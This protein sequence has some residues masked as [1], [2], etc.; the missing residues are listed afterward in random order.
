[1]S[2]LCTQAE[3]FH[4]RRKKTEHNKPKERRPRHPVRNKRGQNGG[5]VDR[6]AAEQ[7]PHSAYHTADQRKP[8][9]AGC[10]VRSGDADALPH[11]KLVGTADQQRADDQQRRINLLQR[12]GTAKKD[13]HQT[14]CP[15][16]NHRRRQH[17]RCYSQVLWQISKAKA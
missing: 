4:R 7:F 13:L 14:R 8:D 12:R 16:K 5:S 3:R 6:S 15:G 17:D 2:F 11:G 9:S 1:M 10:A